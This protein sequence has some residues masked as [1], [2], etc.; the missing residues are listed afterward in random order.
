MDDGQLSVEITLPDGTNL[1]D[2]LIRENLAVRFISIEE[3]AKLSR[4]ILKV[5][6]VDSPKPFKPHHSQ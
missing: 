3:M 2:L 6:K 4:S 1:S 5:L